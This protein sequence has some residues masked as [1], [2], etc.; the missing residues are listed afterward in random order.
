MPVAESIEQGFEGQSD[1]S[2]GLVMIGE[3]GPTQYSDALNIEIRETSVDT[4]GGIRRAFPQAVDLTF[5][6][7]E[8]NAKFNDDTHTGFF[9]PWD[10]GSGIV[11]NIQGIEFVRFPKL[12]QEFFLFAADGR[13]TK[14][15]RGFVETVA[16]EEV[17][18]PT[19]VI[20]FVQAGAGGL[21]NG[22][23]AGVDS[24][25]MFRGDDK[26][27]MR[28]DG[29]VDGF[30]LFPAG[31][32]NNIRGAATGLYFASRLM[33]PRDNDDVYVSDLFET[34]DYNFVTQ[35]FSVARNDGDKIVALVGFHEDT[36]LVF[37][38]NS[39]HAIFNIFAGTNFSDNIIRTTVNNFHGSVARKAIVIAGE[40]VWYIS[41]RGI[42]NIQRNNENKLRGLD[43]PISAEIQP[44][45]DRI[46]FETVSDAAAINFDN[47][48]IFSIPI[49]G[50]L[51][52]NAFLVYDLMANRRQGAWVG[53]WKSAQTRAKQF[54][55]FHTELLFM[56][57]DGVL[58]KM[59]TT[60]PWDSNDALIDTPLYDNALQY[61]VDDIAKVDDNGVFTLFLCTRDTKGNIP[62][63]TD[64]WNEILD[65]EH[66]YDI[67]SDFLT[68]E[69]RHQDKFSEKLRGRQEVIFEHQNPN[70]DLFIRSKDYQT[71]TKIFSS[72]T[73]DRT[74][75]DIADKADWIPD[76]GSL[77][78]R[79][80]HRQDYTLL[81]GEGGI[82]V[83]PDG[84][85]VDGEVI[86]SGPGILIDAS[87]VDLGV[88]ETHS[89]RFI[90]PLLNN[91][92]YQIRIRN[93]RGKLKIKSIG[94]LAKLVRYAAKER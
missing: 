62:P 69:L 31:S 74:K 87:G 50:A 30:K 67:T 94:A 1:F 19:E 56:G 25:V 47:Y 26:N 75:Y 40:Q 55:V 2:G 28:W 36:L 86:V 71:E 49:D 46:N 53:L 80:P 61:F 92:E 7:N 78:F 76:N 22:I 12:N 8:E 68:R 13:V 81:L 93:S 33:F 32:P 39:V 44:I 89:L 16:T 91:L 84:L 52:N 57:Y 6:F 9:F 63:D 66:A 83:G 73:F 37:K 10:W 90:K 34:K 82:V 43:L 17:I 24:I 58:R 38:E 48:I 11:Q 4:R 79:D 18:D 45:I 59:L 85:V 15:I 70:I 27:P 20:D 41:N 29:S 51:E 65:V 64:F 88:F 77:D 54:I 21:A 35:L 42:E 60:D 3:P 14:T 23:S 5:F 72:I